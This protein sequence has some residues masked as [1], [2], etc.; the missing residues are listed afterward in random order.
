MATQLGFLSWIQNDHERMRQAIELL[1]RRLYHLRYEGKR[2]Q[3]NN[4][5]LVREH[6][7]FLRKD[8]CRRVRYEE[9]VLFPFLAT[10]IPRLEPVYSLLCAD[11]EQCRLGLD[12]LSRKAS[13]SDLNEIASRGDYLINLLRHHWLLEES[14]IVGVLQ[15]EL[16]SHEKERLARLSVAWEARLCENGCSRGIHGKVDNRNTIFQEPLSRRVDGGQNLPA[17]ENLPKRRKLIH[18]G[19][20]L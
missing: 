20:F 1:D 8:M 11:H 5:E 14:N 19:R 16:K 4:L 3:G 2:Q 17:R 12:F 7:L 13:Q 6:A 10:H 15:H 9:A 18:L